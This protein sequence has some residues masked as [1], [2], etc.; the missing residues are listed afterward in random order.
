MLSYEFNSR[1]R[2]AKLQQIEYFANENTQNNILSLS[3]EKPQLPHLS[4]VRGCG[5]SA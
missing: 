1:L 4:K 5:D 2:A 3:L